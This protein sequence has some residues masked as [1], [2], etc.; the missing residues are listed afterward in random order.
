MYWSDLEVA[1]VQKFIVE[2]CT[3]CG[4]YFTSKHDLAVFTKYPITILTGLDHT[5]MEADF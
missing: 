1:S 4:E 3:H 2:Y 5:K